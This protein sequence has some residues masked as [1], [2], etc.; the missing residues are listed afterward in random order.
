ME[1]GRSSFFCGEHSGKVVDQCEEIFI[2]TV[3][4][5]S[6]SIW[7]VSEIEYAEVSEGGWFQ[8]FEPGL[9]EF[10]TVCEECSQC[11]ITHMNALELHNV[12]VFVVGPL[13]LIHGVCRTL[14]GLRALQFMVALHG[15]TD[16]SVT[17]SSFFWNDIDTSARISSTLIRNTRPSRNFL[18]FGVQKYPTHHP[19]HLW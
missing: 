18:L 15:L 10:D 11:I 2:T 4:Q 6:S 12:Q 19:H 5:I 9:H 16:T 14:V 1:R 17:R 8:M 7:I 13:V 3:H